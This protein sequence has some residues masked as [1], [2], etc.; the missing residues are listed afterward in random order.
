MSDSNKRFRMSWRVLCLILFVFLLLIVVVGL[1]S[2]REKLV[3][4]D[5][6]ILYATIP[7]FWMS[8]LSKSQSEI[9]CFNNNG[10][11]ITNK[12]LDDS[13]SGLAIVFPAAD[14]RRLYG[15]YYADVCFRLLKIDPDSRSVSFPK[16]SYLN[17]VVVESGC[18]VEAASINDWREV[19]LYLKTVP[20]VAYKNEV[21]YNWA[22]GVWPSYFSRST[23]ARAV[24]FQITNMEHGDYY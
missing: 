9:V 19:S 2:H 1:R 12:F 7:S 21:P 20:L 10:L 5:G 18:S 6:R 14:G 8:F 13:D 23:L 4:T 3:L 11:A 15:L 17:A 16:G 24:D 22:F